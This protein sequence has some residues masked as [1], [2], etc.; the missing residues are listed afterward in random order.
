MS[1]GAE[2]VLCSPHPPG[3]QPDYISQPPVQEVLPHDRALASG[4][5]LEVLHVPLTGLDPINFGRTL[6]VLSLPVGWLSTSI[7]YS[8]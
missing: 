6:H 3:T 2:T 8:L 5:W 7:S 4:M 1:P